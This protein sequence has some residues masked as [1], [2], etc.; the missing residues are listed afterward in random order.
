MGDRNGV[1]Q[2]RRSAAQVR[3][4]LSS[5]IPTPEVRLNV[6]LALNLVYFPVKTCFY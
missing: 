4:S 5:K 1:G 2:R 3:L 6:E